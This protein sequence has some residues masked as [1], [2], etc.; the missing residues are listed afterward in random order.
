MNPNEFV[1]KYKGTIPEHPQGISGQCVCLIRCYFDALGV[2][3]FPS[4]QSAKDLWNVIDQSNFTRV[5]NTILGKPPEG[6]IV[7]MAPFKGG[8][9]GHVF[10]AL[11]GATIWNIPCFESNWSWAKHATLGNHGYLNPKII[12]WFVKK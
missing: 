9:N 3:Q 2:K 7:I 12:G 5:P 8:P 1:N 6:A 11:K 4:V 10:I